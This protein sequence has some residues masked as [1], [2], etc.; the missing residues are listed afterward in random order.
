[1]ALAGDVGRDDL[2]G[3]KTD[4]GGLAL[5]RVGLLGTRD[6]DLDAHAL[7]RGGL[8]GRESRGDGVAGALG[9]AAALFSEEVLG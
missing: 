3:G 8:D 9:F 2:A 5:A 6:A 1:M 4:T 7:E